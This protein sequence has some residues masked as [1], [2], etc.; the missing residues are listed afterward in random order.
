[1]SHKKEKKK[2]FE[3]KLHREVFGKILVIKLIIVFGVKGA[4]LSGLKTSF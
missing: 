2:M 4:I 1:L 3:A